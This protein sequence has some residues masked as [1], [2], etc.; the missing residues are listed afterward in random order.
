MAEQGVAVAAGRRDTVQRLDRV[1]AQSGR[2]IPRAQLTLV[3]TVEG[4]L[5]EMPALAAEAK[6][7]A[8][9]AAKSTGR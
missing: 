7:T 8:A 4:W 5:E 6:F 1:C 2:P 3:G 9:L